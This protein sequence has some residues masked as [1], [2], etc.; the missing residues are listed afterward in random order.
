VAPVQNPVDK[1]PRCR[2]LLNVT[3][4]PNALVFAK[5]RRDRSPDDPS[6]ATLLSNLDTLSSLYGSCRALLTDYDEQLIHVV[7]HHE[8]DFLTSY[9]THMKKTQR[10]LA[11]LVAKARDQERRLENDER[12]V[13]LQ[14]QLKWF[15]EEGE[16][17]GK[18]KEENFNQVDM[19]ST[20][21]QTMQ[22]EKAFMEEQVKASKRQ[23]KLLVMA[24]GKQ[25]THQNNLD[26]DLNEVH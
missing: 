18:M 8:K 12:I 11:S 22:A 9:E 24:L 26:Q 14:R 6:N 7:K 1:A 16:R 21:V 17:L 23:N 20:R 2:I 10:E 13:R 4:N 25:E 5:L 15:T 3:L 19:L